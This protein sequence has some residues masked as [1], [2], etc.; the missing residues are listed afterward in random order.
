MC[1]EWAER[2]VAEVQAL[3]SIWSCDGGFSMDVEEEANLRLAEEVVAGDSAAEFPNLSGRVA[4]KD[5]GAFRV[6]LRFTLPPGYPGAAAPRLQVES[7]APREVH[8][9]LSVAV[10]AAMREQCRDGV[11]DECVLVAADALQTAAI[12]YLES[13]REA[14]EAAL[15]AQPHA[16]TAAREADRLSRCVIWFHHIK[17]LTKRKSIV[18]WARTLR[19]GGFCKPG[20]PGVIVVEGEESD[21]A[22]YVRLIKS[23]R[24]QVNPPLPVIPEADLAMGVRAEEGEALACQGG[25][26]EATRDALAAARKLPAAF[27]ELA[28]SG[29][30]ELGQACRDAGLEQLFLSAMKISRQD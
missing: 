16:S 12:S 13:H 29:M 10:E 25:G 7:A 5:S 23:L 6:G 1:S 28:E 18:E 9:G 2:Q 17:S 30:S 15:H 14:A 22:E 4:L 19:L 11:W 21:V 27:Q 26:T 20:F 3:E 8:D 24:W